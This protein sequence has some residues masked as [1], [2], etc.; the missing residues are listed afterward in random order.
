LGLHA[1]TSKMT[2]QVL[3]CLIPLLRDHFG[4]FPEQQLRRRGTD[5]RTTWFRQVGATSRMARASMNVV[6][7]NAAPT[8]ISRNRDVHWTAYNTDNQLDAT[9]MVY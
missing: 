9:I 4:N 1:L 7:R 3:R 5:P 6:T 2:T 8:R